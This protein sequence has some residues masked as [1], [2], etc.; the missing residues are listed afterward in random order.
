MWHDTAIYSEIKDRCELNAMEMSI[1]DLN[2]QG[3]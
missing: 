2:P 3:Q 1:K